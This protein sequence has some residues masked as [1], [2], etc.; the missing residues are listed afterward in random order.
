MPACVCAK[1]L[2]L[3][4]TLCHPMDCSP[5]GSSVHGILQAR[6]LEWVAISFYRGSSLTQGSNPGFP[7]C[8]QILYHLPLSARSDDSETPSH[9][10][11]PHLTP[12]S[13]S[14]SIFLLW[15]GHGIPFGPHSPFQEKASLRRCS[16]DIHP[17]I[18]NQRRPLSVSLITSSWFRPELLPR[19][20][21]LPVWRT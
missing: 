18:R 6:I 7:H 9:N 8:R 21:I 15:T 2:Q 16:P 4:S 10:L 1:L 14:Q 5:P 3:Y 20:P 17:L 12:L 19:L 13:T 11:S